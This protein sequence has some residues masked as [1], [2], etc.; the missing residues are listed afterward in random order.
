MKLRAAQKAI[1]SASMGASMGAPKGTIYEVWRS[2]T[3]VGVQ[4][5]R[6]KARLVTP[7]LVGADS[8]D[9]TLILSS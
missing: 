4:S 8:I 5:K 3:R 9:S 7:D 1:V 2:N 6:D